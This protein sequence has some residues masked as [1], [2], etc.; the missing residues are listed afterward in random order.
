MGEKIVV[1]WGKNLGKLKVGLE[2]LL[3]EDGVA[4]KKRKVVVFVVEG[5]GKVEWGRGEVPNTL[6]SFSFIIIFFPFSFTLYKPIV[7]L[8]VWIHNPCEYFS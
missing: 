1:E 8:Y 7:S 2:M 6:H 3:V 5:G 4:G